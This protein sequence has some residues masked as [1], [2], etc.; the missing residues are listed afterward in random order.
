MY[1]SSQANEHARHQSY[2]IWPH[3]ALDVSRKQNKMIEHVFYLQLWWYTKMCTTQEESIKILYFLE[4]QKAGLRT[5]CVWKMLIIPPPLA[6]ALHRSSHML[7]YKL[8]TYNGGLYWAATR[9][10]RIQIKRLDFRLPRG[11]RRNLCGH[12]R[13]QPA[14]LFIVFGRA[15]KWR[16]LLTWASLSLRAR[17]ADS[18]RKYLSCSSKVFN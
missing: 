3:T 15:G 16:K 14:T 2:K 18:C 7:L 11:K 10:F 5:P 4:S 6:T 17:F 12:K 1:L 13:P 8:F 9:L